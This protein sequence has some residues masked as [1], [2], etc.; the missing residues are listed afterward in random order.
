ML[1]ATRGDKNFSLPRELYDNWKLWKINIYI[2]NRYVRK[3]EM[4]LKMVIIMLNLFN[5][6]AEME[7]K[8][9]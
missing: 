7:L 8:K 5:F 1:G 9:A 3:I 6:D 2:D 4:F